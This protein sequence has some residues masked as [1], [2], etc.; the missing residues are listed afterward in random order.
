[1]Y[2]QRR[3]GTTPTPS[4]RG[5]TGPLTDDQI[6]QEI[7]SV[8]TKSA[9]HAEGY[10]KVWAK[11]RFKGI[12][13]SKRRVL[14][15]MQDHNLLCSRRIKGPTGRRAHDGLITTNRV[16]EMWGTDQTSCFTTEEGQVAIFFAVDH[17][18]MECIGIHA[19]LL[20]ISSNPSSI[21][22]K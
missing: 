18:S 4:R 8:L 16:D 14:R 20:C 15:L 21:L 10:R 19:A 13:T 6:V 3:C 7:G 2:F 11:L 1:M 5:P 22:C 9:F 17:C 12:S